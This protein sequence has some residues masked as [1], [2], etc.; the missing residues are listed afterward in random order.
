MS[1]ASVAFGSR[2]SCSAKDPLTG[3]IELPCVDTAP[4]SPAAALDVEKTTADLVA[5][6]QEELSALRAKNEKMLANL[7]H[8]KSLLEEATASNKDLQ[9]DMRSK[10][11]NL[12]NNI[13][14]LKNDLKNVTASRDKFKTKLRIES[15]LLKQARMDSEKLERQ[16]KQSEKTRAMERELLNLYRELGNNT[17]YHTWG[18]RIRILEAQVV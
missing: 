5:Q 4:D 9:E 16:L 15:D 11:T 6:M 7:R 17:G 3:D 8:K 13:V 1:A 12:Q 18:K 14:S 2:A 10:E